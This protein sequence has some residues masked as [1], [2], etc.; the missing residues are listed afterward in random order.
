MQYSTVVVFLK[1]VN[2]SLSAFFVLRLLLLLCPIFPIFDIIRIF[3]KITGSATF[4][5]LIIVTRNGKIVWK[6]GRSTSMLSWNLTEQ[7][8]I[9]GIIVKNMTCSV[10]DHP[11]WGDFHAI[12]DKKEA[13]MLQ[14]VKTWNWK[15]IF[16]H[17][18]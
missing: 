8:K 2:L 5:C 17:Q 10:E 4:M 15:W 9:P 7:P 12:M 6:H 18:I 1:M 14:I 11:Y 16:Q 13:D 3:L